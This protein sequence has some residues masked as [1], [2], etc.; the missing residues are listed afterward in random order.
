[1]AVATERRVS[2]P[3]SPPARIETKK[4]AREKTNP[5]LKTNSSRDA[6]RVGALSGCAA[7]FSVQT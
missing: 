3:P 7:S 5:K 2:R 6:F 1:M 4:K